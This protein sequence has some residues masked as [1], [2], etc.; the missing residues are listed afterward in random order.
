[1]I[2]TTRTSDLNDMAAEAEQV[3]RE[4]ALSNRV[5]Y[6]GVSPLMCYQCGD[7]IEEKRRQLLPG[8]VLC[9]ACA[10]YNELKGKR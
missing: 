9:A 1:M 8:T 5:R 10:Q 2:E 4:A 3:A 6:T 7:D